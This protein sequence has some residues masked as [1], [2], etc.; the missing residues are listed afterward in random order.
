MT[1]YRKQGGLL[2]ENQSLNQTEKTELF[3]NTY[4]KIEKE[5]IVDYFVS[6]NFKK[7]F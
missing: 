6:S 7:G 3:K 1:T 4:N 5:F 2:P